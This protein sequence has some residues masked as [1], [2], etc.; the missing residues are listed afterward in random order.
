MISAVLIMT[1]KFQKTNVCSG[2]QK[3]V[4][5]GWRQVKTQDHNLGKSAT[6][7]TSLSIYLFQSRKKHCE[8]W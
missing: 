4:H 7:S 5:E 1:C 2:L 3:V 8:I 6:F